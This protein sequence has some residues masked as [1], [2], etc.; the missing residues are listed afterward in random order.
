MSEFVGIILAAGIGKRMKSELPKP[1]HKVCGL[2]IIDHI[3]SSLQ[4]S[5]INRLITV[6][7]HKG[8][9]LCDHLKD[10]SEI[11]WQR[12]Q[13]G[14]GDAVIQAEEILAGYDGNILILPGDAP[15]IR[16]ES[17]ISLM[18]KHEETGPSATLLTM[19]LNDPASYGRIVRDE[20][21]KFISITEFK[22]ASEEIKK[23][24]EVNTGIYC[25]KSKDLFMALDH[26]NDDNEQ[27]EYYLT[28][29]LGILA[30]MDLNVETVK[31]DD[32]NE[33]LGINSRQELSVAESIMRDRKRKQLMSDGVTLI[34]PPS[35]FVDFDVEIGQD[36]VIMPFSI[37]ANGTKIGRECLIGPNVDIDNCRIG[38][39]NRIKECHMVEATVGSNCCIGPY[40]YMRP[41]TVVADHVKLGDFVEIKNTTIGEGTK[42]PHLSYIGDSTVG[43][44]VNIGC[45]TITC[46]YDGFKKHRTV[47]E[48]EAFIGS[49]SNLVAPVTVEKGSYVASGSTITSTVPAGSL[50]IARCKQE[51]KDGWAE[52]RKEKNVKNV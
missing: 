42:V 19:E 43:S 48:D 30:E 12:Q 39:G 11:V 33:A 28:D 3:V 37:I 8:E 15:L 17:L 27:S 32:P 38:D 13:L 45:G 4:N 16:S 49:N 10:R 1:L 35:T 6:V 21:G 7:G 24:R 50:A 25:F 23:I 18:K 5:N 46:N 29:V 22:D 26:I 52:R 41:G 34:D 51:I 47:I 36:T 44:R 40:C 20:S 14:T 9:F 31:T 2:P